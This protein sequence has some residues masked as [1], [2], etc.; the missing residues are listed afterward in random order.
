MLEMGSLSPHACS[1]MQEYLDEGKV[2]ICY[3][4][5]AREYGIYLKGAPLRFEVIKYCPWCGSKLP[6]PLRE[7]WGD[8]LDVMELYAPFGEDRDR[9]PKEFWSDEWW[10]ARNY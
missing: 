2:G 6:E 7:A 4:P 9:V 3:I 8:L 5:F 1:E 10:K